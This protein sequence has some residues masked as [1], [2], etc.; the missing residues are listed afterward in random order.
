MSC[1]LLPAKLRDIM[2]IKHSIAIFLP[3]VQ[4]K[5]VEILVRGIQVPYPGIYQS[6][7]GFS[8]VW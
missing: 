6:F 8:M 2:I 7:V 3:Q 1:N 5:S 4:G